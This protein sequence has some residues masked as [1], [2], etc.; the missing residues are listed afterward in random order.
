MTPSKDSSPGKV[1]G[2]E[3]TKALFQVIDDYSRALQLL[4]DYDHQRVS[5]PE[6]SPGAVHPLAYEEAAWIVDRL[7]EKFSESGVFGIEKDNGMASA[8]GAIMQS[9][10]GE[11]AY[12]SFEEKAANLLY[13]LVK[14][15]A[16]V[17]GNKRIAAALFL[18]FL[19]KNGR[20]DKNR[21]LEE[22]LVPMT[23]MI[24]ESRPEEKVFIV[25]V[26]VHILCR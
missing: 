19:K 1:G 15:H 10:G 24:A 7:R 20:L 12:P 13:F 3:Q 8:L 16:F 22:A 11:D 4:D 17:D 6:T 2:D 25:R 18:W 14:N 9:A 23:L 5:L 26:V 21:I